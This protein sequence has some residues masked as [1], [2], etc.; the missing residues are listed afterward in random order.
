MDR[1]PKHATPD[2]FRS[3]VDRAALAAFIIL[4]I[5]ASFWLVH[6]SFD[7]HRDEFLYLDQGNHLAWGYVSVP[8]FTSWVSWLVHALGGSTFWVQFF[9]ALFGALTIAAVWWS[10]RSLGGGLFA[11]ALSATALLCSGLLRLDLLYQPN[12]MDV[13]AWTMVLVLVVQW[14]R[15]ERPPWLYAAAFAFAIG[16]LNKY[17]IVFLGVGIAGGL[18]LTRQRSLLFTRHT[19]IALVI[20][21]VVIGPNLIWQWR[22]DWPVLAH[23]EELNATQLANNDRMDFLLEQPKMFFAEL[24]VLVAAFLGLLF[25]RPMVRYRFVFFTWLIVLGLLTLGKAKPYYA[26]GLY[27]ILLGF[28]SIAL[29]HWLAEG[30]LRWLRPVLII[31]IIAIFLPL[32]PFIFPNRPAEVIAADADRIALMGPS[33]WEDGEEHAL[34]QDF[35]DMRGWRELAVKVDRLRKELLVQGDV[36]VFCNNYGEAGAIN[37]YAP[38]VRPAAVTFNADYAKWFVLD[39]DYRSMIYVQEAEDEEFRATADARRFGQV[40][41]VGSITDPWALERGTRIYQCTDPKEPIMKVLWEGRW[42]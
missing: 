4:K 14:V 2:R 35:A 13:L 1:S 30:W 3:V 6:P 32:V 19:L 8:P 37:F 5:V 10:V 26:F 40:L 11:R 16:I 27:P 20:L 29:E 31:A 12:S 39:R 9:P 34:P 36:L 21:L 41:L 25:H 22:N 38:R 15:T 33:R 18:L 28:G 7:R 42:R 23:M 24:L 17:S